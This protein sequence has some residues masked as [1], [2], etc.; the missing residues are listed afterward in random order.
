MKRSITASN[1]IGTVEYKVEEVAQKVHVDNGIWLLS[2]NIR[3]NFVAKNTLG[4]ALYKLCT[5]LYKFSRL[6]TSFI[7]GSVVTSIVVLV[8]STGKQ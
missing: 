3:A 5:L 6:Y 8:H 2:A 4:R 7:A 1:D